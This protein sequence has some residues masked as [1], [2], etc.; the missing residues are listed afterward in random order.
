MSSQKPALAE[1]SGCLALML[2]SGFLP[3][4]KID[5]LDFPAALSLGYGGLLLLLRDAHVK[6]LN[7]ALTLVDMFRSQIETGA[8]L[9]IILSQFA[10]AAVGA[11]LLSVL[12][13]GS[14]ASIPASAAAAAAAA[15][16]LLIPQLVFGAALVF[17]YIRGNDGSV[18]EGPWL[19]ALMYGAFSIGGNATAFLNPAVALG[20]NVYRGIS[21][22]ST[23][24][25]AIAAVVGV[26][27]AAAAVAFILDKISEE[28]LQTSELIGAFF[29]SFG[30]LA[31]ASNSS[32][33]SSTSAAAVGFAFY[34]AAIVR[35]VAPASGG[36]LNPAVTGGAILSEGQR[37]SKD[38]VVVWGYQ[39]CGAAA[40]ALLLSQV[41]ASPAAAA[42]A[43]TAGDWR[44]VLQTIGL[45]ALLLI[46]YCSNMGDF[47]GSPAAAFVGAVYGLSLLGGSG[48]LPINPAVSL[49]AAA[50]A[51]AAAAP[52][53]L[54]ETAAQVVLPFLGCIFGAVLL[55][56]VP[57]E[58]KR[59]L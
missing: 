56:L 2:I 8:A 54:L 42:A 6:T 59:R 58:Y 35:M 26:P 28:N 25:A 21:G 51:A 38:L 18:Y 27:L 22:A 37:I 57:S 47:F 53:N 36:S 33:S 24:A 50:A 43:T 49:A 55:R 11:F 12:T 17:A 44:P 31:A 20:A 14:N 29:L 15:G 23:D 34:A 4:L 10:G 52:L 3:L 5:G 9:M 1:F 48:W 32:S 7:P 13:T 41:Y 45:S 39:L 19:A 46:S 16:P 40:A 30:L